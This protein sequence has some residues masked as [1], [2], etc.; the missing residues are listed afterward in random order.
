MMESR[1]G[2]TKRRADRIIAATNDGNYKFAAL[3]GAA[4]TAA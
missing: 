3:T 1:N 4:A 2:V